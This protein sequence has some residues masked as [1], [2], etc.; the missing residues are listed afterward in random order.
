MNFSSQAQI[1]PAP[2]TLAAIVFT[3]VVG[4][5]RHVQINE[6]RAIANFQRDLQLM[7]RICDE[8]GGKILKT[9]G[10]GAL[11]QF[12]SANQAVQC[13]LEI[14]N[15]LFEQSKYYAHEDVLDHRMGIHLGDVMVTATDVMGDGVNIAARLQA[16]AKSGSILLSRTVYDVV[17]G[18]IKFQA[19]CLGPRS[20]KGIKDPVVVWEIPA[21]KQQEIAKR[22]QALEAFVPISHSIPSANSGLKGVIITITSLIIIFVVTVVIW[23]GVEMT[24]AR[25]AS[26]SQKEQDVALHHQS[27]L[28]QLLKGNNKTQSSSSPSDPSLTN[29]VTSGVNPNTDVKGLTSSLGIAASN[30]AVSDP[31]IFSQLKPL[32][33]NYDFQGM[34]NIIQQSK[35]ATTIDGLSAIA[36]YT[37]LSEYMAWLSNELDGHTSD[38][39]LTV[40]SWPGASGSAEV[41]RTQPQSIGVRINGVETDYQV[42]RLSKDEVVALGEALLPLSD[43][44]DTTKTAITQAEIQALQEE[45]SRF[46]SE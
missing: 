43:S 32:F 31:V 27:R 10:D 19:T 22:N 8:C 21:L 11:M 29:P 12:P 42:T 17:K 38:N 46:K 37:G 7:Q 30:A 20:L 34:A 28:G 3:D 23:K 2:R 18:K 40:Q 5:S 36:T 33:A 15:A 9:L 26:I 16:V 24:K 45:E 25:Q 13:A 44:T 41:F 35:Y 6:N 39:P 4:Y 14:Q 1:D